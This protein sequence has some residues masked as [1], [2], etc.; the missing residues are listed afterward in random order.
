MFRAN[1]FGIKEMNSSG[2][3]PFGYSSFG[4]SPGSGE[5]GADPDALSQTT[6]EQWERVPGHREWDP[7]MDPRSLYTELTGRTD[8][9]QKGLLRRP[10]LLAQYSKPRSQSY[11]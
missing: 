1:P 11:L 2:F 8:F 6:R 4:Y 9:G 10:D 5:F 3:V 7:P